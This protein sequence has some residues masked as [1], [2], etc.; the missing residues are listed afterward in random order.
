M[1]KDKSTCGTTETQKLVRGQVEVRTPLDLRALLNLFFY[2]QEM[3]SYYEPGSQNL[4]SVQG[5]PGIYQR[6][7]YTRKGSRKLGQISQLLGLPIV[8]GQTFILKFERHSYCLRDLYI[9]SQTT[10]Q[11][12]HFLIQV[13]T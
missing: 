6:I 5:G 2:V 9:L 10:N 4:K 13:Q 11:I 3:G 1:A 8:C 12:Q 7:M